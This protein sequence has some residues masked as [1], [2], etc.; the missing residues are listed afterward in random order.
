MLQ[1]PP[2]RWP[3]Q[4][5]ALISQYYGDTSMRTHIYTYSRLEDGPRRRAHTLPQERSYYLTSTSS[6]TLLPNPL[7]SFLTKPLTSLLTKPQ[8]SRICSPTWS[9]SRAYLC[10]LWVCTTASR[11]ALNL[12]VYEVVYEASVWSVGV[13]TA[14]RYALNLPNLPVYERIQW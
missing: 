8:T 7:S 13:T 11:Y 1:L 3:S 6:P 2:R 5:R 12:P 4:A 14:S 9:R 10:G